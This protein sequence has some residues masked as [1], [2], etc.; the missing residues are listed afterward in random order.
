MKTTR[1]V[2]SE[3]GSWK[4]QKAYRISE[5]IAHVSKDGR[6]LWKLSYK[7]SKYS[8]PQLKR[9]GLD[10]LKHGGLHNTPVTF[11]VRYV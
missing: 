2:V 11:E 6:L 1:I 7:S 3:Q 8:M 5:Y 4:W 9:A 10:T